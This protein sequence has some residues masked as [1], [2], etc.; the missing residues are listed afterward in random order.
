MSLDI[1]S[2]HIKCMFVGKAFPVILI[3][4]GSSPR[5]TAASS[6][7]GE[8]VKEAARTAKE[9]KVRTKAESNCG[10]ATD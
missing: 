2:A 5:K 1:R 10:L 3:W 8:I 7:D 6:T 4:L 9:I